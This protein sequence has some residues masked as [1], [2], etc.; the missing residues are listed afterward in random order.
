MTIGESIRKIRKERGLS[1]SQLSIKSKVPYHSVYAWESGKCFPSLMN[2][3]SI[4]DALD[5]SLDELVGRS[6][7]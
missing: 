5:V 7:G 4:A 3:I 2:L 1:A 6:R